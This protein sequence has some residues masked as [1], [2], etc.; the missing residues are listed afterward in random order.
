MAMDRYRRN[1][2]SGVR[3][4]HPHISSCDMKRRLE[5]IGSGVPTKERG[6]DEQARRRTEASNTVDQV[7]SAASTAAAISAAARARHTDEALRT[8]PENDHGEPSLAPLPV[9]SDTCEA[10]DQHDTCCGSLGSG[11]RATTSSQGTLP[12]PVPVQVTLRSCPGCKEV[13]QDDLWD[14][15]PCC[16]KPVCV[17]CFGKMIVTELTV[18]AEVNLHPPIQCPHCM[19][20]FAHAEFAE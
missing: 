18:S 14:P 3:R 16:G 10:V 5:S 7:A 6:T 19:H 1:P 8:E 9:S 15:T 2:P 11:S 13:P 4:A 17:E 20:A 12:V